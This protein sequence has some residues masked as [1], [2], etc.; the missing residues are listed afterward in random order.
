[1]RPAGAGPMYL[2]LSGSGVDAGCGP[3]GPPPRCASA[4]AGKRRIATKV[5][6]HEFVFMAGTITNCQT[7]RTALRHRE[8]LEDVRRAGGE[9]ETGIARRHA[10]QE[11]RVE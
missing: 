10:E 9:T 6:R 8:R 1:M 4:T 3:C 11:T 2:N 7:F 5:S